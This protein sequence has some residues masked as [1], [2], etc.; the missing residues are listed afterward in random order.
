[1]QEITR[2]Y[3][4]LGLTQRGMHLITSLC[5]F[6]VLPIVVLV[7]AGLFVSAPSVPSG[8]AYEFL[9]NYYGKV[10]QGNQRQALYQD[11]LTSSFRS[12]NSW[13]SYIA[14]WRTQKSVT[15]ASVIPAPGDSLEF[16]VS[17]VFH[18]SGGGTIEETYNFWLACKGLVGGLRSRVSFLGCPLG[19]LEIDNQQLT[20]TG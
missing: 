6:L 14:F 13:R 15:V 3:P 17:L 5:K 16:G 18:P 20:S 12:H 11:D 7:T 8:R 4:V 10:T 9:A 2:Q 19:D 1:M